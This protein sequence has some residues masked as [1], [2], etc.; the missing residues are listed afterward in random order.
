MLSHSANA[1][2]YRFIFDNALEGIVVVDADLIIQEANKRAAEMLGCAVADLIGKE[3]GCFIDLEHH[4]WH[5]DNS[6]PI[7]QEYH[8]QLRHADAKEVW[9]IAIV[10]PLFSSAGTYQGTVLRLRD[11]TERRHLLGEIHRKSLAL[12]VVMDGIAIL[13][14]RG[15]ITYA[16]KAFAQLFGYTFAKDLLG[17]MWQ[18]LFV[19]DIVPQLETEALGALQEL[20]QW[21]GEVPAK[22]RDGQLFWAEQSL[23]KTEDGSMICVCRDITERVNFETELQKRELWLRAA[24]EGGL[25]AFFMLEWQPNHGF[26][27]V[28]INKWGEQLFQRG[29]QEI[30]GKP[31]TEL[32]SNLHL[33]ELVAKYQSVMDS[34]KPLAEEFQ[35]NSVW[36]WHQIVSLPNGVAVTMRNITER[37]LA[38]AALQAS[39]QRYRLLAEHST[40]II[41][42]HAPTGRFVYVSPACNTLLG[43]QPI[44]LV[45]HSLFD[46]VYEE[47]R[48]RVELAFRMATERQVSNRVSYRAGCKDGRNFIWLETIFQPVK[49]KGQERLREVIATSRDITQRRAME[50]DLLISSERLRLALEASNDGL[51]DCN[52]QTGECYVSPRGLQMLDYVDGEFQPQIKEWR[53][54]CHPEDQLRA[55]ELLQQHLSGALPNYDVE[56][57]VLT[58]QGR[59][60]W[61]RLRGQ[62]VERKPATNEPVRLL[63]TFTDISDRKEMELLIKKRS[64]VISE[65]Y[66]ITAERSLSFHDKLAG[67]LKLGCDYLEMQTAH[68]SKIEQETV[69]L[70]GVWRGGQYYSEQMVERNRFERSL[71]YEVFCQQDLLLIE[72]IDQSQWRSHPSQQFN[73]KQTYIGA[74]VQVGDEMYGVLCFYSKTKPSRPILSADVEIIRLMVQWLGAELER[75]QRNAELQR[76]FERL[77]LLK[78]ITS[79][80]RQTLD[81]KQ[82]FA[83]AVQEIGRALQV[84]RCLIYTYNPSEDQDLVLAAEYLAEGIDSQNWEKINVSHNP[85]AQAVLAS[86]SAVVSPNVFADPL[87]AQ[88]KEVCE[89]I[90]L[91]SMVVVRTSYNGQPNGV[92]ALHQC[93]YFRHWTNDEV[94]LLESI[95]G[96][97]GIAI[98]QA[99]LLAQEKSRS[100]E[101]EQAKIMAEQSSRAKSEF[102]AMMSHEIRTPMNA[103]LGMTQLV[104]QDPNLKPEHR[105]ALETVHSSGSALLNI[106]NDI[107]DLS[108]I[109]AGRLELENSPF[110]VWAVVRDTCL[111]LQHL[112]QQKNIHLHYFIDAQVPQ[113]LLGDST[114]IKQILLNL[115]SN[116]IKFTHQ[117][118]VQ[119]TLAEWQGRW[120]FRVADTGVGI[121]E[122]FMERIFQP[123]MQGDAST[124]RQYG[125]T[126]LGLAI[127]RRLC[128]MMGGYL[129]VYSGRH[130]GGNPPPQWQAPEQEYKGAIFFVL[131]PLPTASQLQVNSDTSDP[132]TNSSSQ[133]MLASS[134][135]AQL[136]ILLAEDNPVNQKVATRLLGKLGYTATVVNNG[137]EALEAV[138]QAQYDVVFLDVQ[139][140]EMDGLQAAGLIK[141][142]FAEPPYL[143]AMTANAMQGDREECLKA[144]MDDYVSKPIRL[145]DL[146][147]A[148]ERAYHA[149]L[150]KIG[151]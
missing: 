60:L 9:A 92:V 132:K 98:A 2:W 21:R 124:T 26:I 80:I 121:P 8:F 118:S 131:L 148:L 85:L 20:G 87:L 29:R 136:K 73:P 42:R 81:S 38:E 112:A 30:I 133:P 24:L 64:L 59:W 79:E 48:A 96:Q 89:A 27:V 74:P 135:L 150:A 62:V 119:L 91:K 6:T 47:D 103:V 101:M 71:C 123:F 25:D 13:N 72:D 18:E 138:R 90:A 115:L 100:L 15:V 1:T 52:V 66:R 67:L 86:D 122:H 143:I 78:R 49:D 149:S 126:G 140:P 106:L 32:H 46:L 137:L 142:E 5:I 82:I 105:D 39:E 109:E 95:A 57:R 4:Q 41:A 7:S 68:L 99:N 61:V 130:T 146:Q 102:L 44:E 56:L 12:E 93:D 40:D 139:M 116:A 110:D 28:E 129:W 88:F 31:L 3:L 22:R 107:L 53:N 134:N 14:Q 69:R 17:K 144:G 16:N 34:G 77:L 120:L 11:T 35:H 51:W 94:D 147:S 114:R 76:Q 128:E 84:S 104:L 55:W 113:H 65:L 45:G 97:I 141:A 117:G 63:G 33:A 75:Q 23:N 127:S 108:K 43:F 125:G 36:Y 10:T 54:F 58:R 50:Q 145:E 111:L 37:K 151:T 19:S 83:T 70:V